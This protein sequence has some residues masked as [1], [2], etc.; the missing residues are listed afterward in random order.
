MDNQKEFSCLEHHG[1]IFSKKIELEADYQETLP[2]YCDDIYRVV[3]CCGRS[4]I[5]SAE[6]NYNEIKLSGKSEI[7]L[8]YFNDNSSLCYVDFEEDFVKTINADG[9]T[10]FAYV[11]ADIFDK[12][13][14]FR[15]INQRRIDIH[16]SS[17]IKVN[18][19]DKITCP[20][21]CSCENSKLRIQRV[22][23]AKFINSNISK[24]EFDE[25]FNL[26]AEN[27]P[28][29]RIISYS[30]FVTPGEI[31]VIKDKALVKAVVNVNVV[32]TSD[33][34][35][36]NILN[37]EYS[38][39]A[40]KI[41][42]VQGINENDIPITDIKIGNLIV[43]SKANGGERINTFDIFGELTLNT[44]F[45]N[46]S[47]E[48]IITDGYFPNYLSDCS[49][50]DYSINLAGEH[51]NE[52]KMINL[53]FVLPEGVKKIIE[54]ALSVGD[55][56]FKNSNL[57]AGVYME[58]ICEN[59][60]GE[61][62]SVSSVDEFELSYSGYN[63][64]VAAISVN[65]YDYTISNSNTLDIRLSTNINAYLYNNETVKILSD[66]NCGDSIKTAPALT[67]YF[68]K[69]NESIWNI[70]KIF[71]SDSEV[72]INENALSGDT[73]DSDRVLIIPKA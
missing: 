61:L 27:E 1:K 58:A 8:T 49:Y 28:I 34:D 12:Y 7:C 11:C 48:K 73:L 62:S 16:I 39:N 2:A 41:V 37:S 46:E 36:E 70:A 20:S 54:V 18:V 67:V 6:I 30:G 38:F 69:E 19:Y 63:E 17:V 10:D 33:N 22:S 59:E 64:A 47:E 52:N 15:I 51:I 60:R 53:S 44:V 68:G 24:I 29:K 32:Y 56:C 71:S 35:D 3:K 45:I 43:K 42:E 25:S 31:K 55:T 72:I 4:Y 14:N 50:S 57:V 13:T 21:L 66:I 23:T 26:P 9:L 5:T 40:S 65:S